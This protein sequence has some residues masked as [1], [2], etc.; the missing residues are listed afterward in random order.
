M[1]YARSLQLIAIQTH[2]CRYEHS[3]HTERGTTRSE[4]SFGHPRAFRTHIFH[5]TV[6]WAVGGEIK[7]KKGKSV[8]TKS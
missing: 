2:T 7:Y 6:N 8:R 3:H 4:R 5:G 1:Y